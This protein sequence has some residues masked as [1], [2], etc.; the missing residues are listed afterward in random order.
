MLSISSWQ[1]ERCI[2]IAFPYSSSNIASTLMEDVDKCLAK[3][4]IPFPPEYR[5]KMTTQINICIQNL[6]ELEKSK[7]EY[8]KLRR[9]VTQ[10]TS[11]LGDSIVDAQHTVGQLSVCSEP[12]KHITN[13][14]IYEEAR[15]DTI[16]ASFSE[17][18]NSAD[19]CIHHTM[20]DIDVQISIVDHKMD[21]YKTH[22]ESW[23]DMTAARQ[24]AAEICKRAMNLLTSE[25]SIHIMTELDS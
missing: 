5:P 16:T 9:S 12:L 10:I 19:D 24:E 22:Y 4:Y 7:P 11:N 3:M 6:I 8:E 15:F 14:Q 13:L 2:S 25:V 1:V 18:L 21:D 23:L 17:N 20:D